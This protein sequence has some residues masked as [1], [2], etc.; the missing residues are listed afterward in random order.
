[1]LYQSSSELVRS[2]DAH[3]FEVLLAQQLTSSN[4]TPQ[5][6]D[7]NGCLY[8]LLEA[9][10]VPEPDRLLAV[11]QAGIKTLNQEIHT[12]RVYGRQIGETFTDW[13]YQFSRGSDQ[14]WSL[15]SSQ[16][17]QSDEET[18]APNDQNVQ[19]VKVEHF[20]VCGLG[21]LGQH[22]V[23]ALTSFATKNFMVKV[24]AIDSKP[25]ETW[26]VDQLPNLLRG[27]IVKGDCRQD[28]ILSQ[29]GIH[30]CRAILVVTNDE[31]VNIETAIAARRLNPNIRIIVG[32][33]KQNL[34]E[35]LKHKLSNFA[36]FE[37]LALPAESFALA[38][39]GEETVGLFKVGDRQLR[40]VEHQVTAGDARFE[41]VFAHRLYRDSFR[42]LKYISGN[43]SNSTGSGDDLA[44]VETYEESVR[45]EENEPLEKMFYQWDPNTQIQPGDKL[46]YIEEVEQHIASQL[47]TKSRQNWF[48]WQQRIKGLTLKNWRSMVV[49]VWMWIVAERTRKVTGLGLA[50][51]FCLGVL[52]AVLLKFTVAGMTWQ[53]AISSAV[54]LLLGGYGD[55]FGGLELTASIPWWVQV[56]CLLITAISILFV[57][58]VLGLLA[59]RLLSARFDF[60]K[61]RSPVPKANHIVLIGLGRVGQ[62][63]A[64]LLH[65][66]R[67]PFVCL[68]YLKE[69]QDFMPQIPLIY[70]PIL[71]GLVDLNL[72]QAKSLIVAT[73][74]QMLNL[75]VALTARNAAY[76][77]TRSLNLVICAQDQRFCDH[78]NGLM[79]EM[80]A[81]CVNALAAEAFAGA[82]FG[83]NILSLFRLANQT[84]LVTE[85]Q[86][87]AA[88]TLNGKLLAQIAYGYG[89]VPIA[90]LSESGETF[91]V[92]PSDDVRLQVGDR[93]ITLATINGL[94]RIE[95]GTLAFPRRWQLQVL[96]P[97]NPGVTFYAG[98]V[99]ENISGC[100]LSAARAF[101]DHLPQVLNV[102]GVMELS[103]YDHQADHLVRK[104]KKLVPV[105]LVP[106]E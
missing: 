41:K 47:P 93:L 54:I 89:V 33:G 26:E 86:I 96:R 28:T 65:E 14:S 36:A 88:D 40:I 45:I 8:I 83:E 27:G 104:L 24:T 58:S 71:E 39:L 97:L 55:V 67:Q 52:G 10:T 19:A 79:P 105:R 3:R 82:A 100:S 18:K 30:E 70:S 13:V 63:I 68:T 81:L 42:L 75:E 15:D 74:D 12:V 43:G 1:M 34:N 37:P 22:C 66:L 62:R 17:Y 21:K 78:L 2:K 9:I 92:M 50:I 84:I 73:D 38:A 6:A 7:E 44:S 102:P 103:L 87:D 61:R 29:A 49:R 64:M 69:Q 46:F 94:Q 57:L 16:Q 31:N 106:I 51:A 76:Q 59:D 95:W 48:G 90:Y 101:M 32:S 77:S 56:I 20:L 11:I 72:A 53:A 99:L 85:Y 98:N 91:K 5:V 35:L 80:K 60:L 4:I 23:V 25:P